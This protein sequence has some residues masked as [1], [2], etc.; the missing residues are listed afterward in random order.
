MAEI[1][2]ISGETIVVDDG[3]LDALTQHR[4]YI[5]RTKRAH[6]IY[7]MAR[8][9]MPDGRH[10]TKGI[11]RLI[12]GD[13]VG[14][15]VDHINGNGLDN[16]RSNLRVVTRQ[17]NLQ[18]QKARAGSSAYRGV[19]AANGKWLAGITHNYKRIHCGTFV[20]EEAAAQAY[21]AKAREL[22]GEFA[23]LNFPRSDER[24]AG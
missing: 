20:T 12:M 7:A 5:Q 6:T 10:V 8:V 11:H 21:D 17:Q 24:L 9:A 13:P 19:R 4:W 3:D 22:F 18:N 1:M 15:D 2:A 16:R 23:A 14:M